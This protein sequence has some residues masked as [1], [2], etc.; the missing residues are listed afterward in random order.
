TLAAR[1]DADTPAVMGML[2]PPRGNGTYTL[3]TAMTS[4]ERATEK[5]LRYEPAF[6]DSYRWQCSTSGILSENLPDVE[7][8]SPALRS[9][10]LEGKYGNLASLLIP[11]FDLGEHSCYAG[12]DSFEHL[13]RPLSSDPR[14]NRKLILPEFICAF[15]KY[16]NII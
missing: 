7:T 6:A 1:I 15:N 13:F 11:H 3:T 5:S 14:L 2:M 16:C 9:S 4:I 12:V 8:V 10:I